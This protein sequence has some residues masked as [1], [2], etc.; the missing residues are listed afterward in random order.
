MCPCV[1]GV[2]V[3]F[4]G[5]WVNV[6]HATP[7][8]NFSRRGYMFSKRVSGVMNSE[9]FMIFWLLYQKGIDEDF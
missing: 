2:R 8:V 9:G 3:W 4:V 1:Y 6:E 7:S 5:H